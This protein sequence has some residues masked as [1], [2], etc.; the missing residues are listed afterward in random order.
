MITDRQIKGG[1]TLIRCGASLSTPDLNIITVLSKRTFSAFNRSVTD[2][3]LSPRASSYAVT[4]KF[5]GFR[6]EEALSQT[7][8]PTLSEFLSKGVHYQ[9]ADPCRFSFHYGSPDSDT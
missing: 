3:I 6:P 5:T 2:F 9:C 1:Y 7:L 8:I 4:V